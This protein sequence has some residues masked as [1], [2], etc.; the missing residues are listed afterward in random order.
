MNI[1]QLLEI[2]IE[3]RASDL[4]LLAGYPPMIRIHGE[5]VQVAGSTA[6]S[7]P[8]VTSL[9]FQLLT[10]TQ[11]Q[12][13]EKNFELDFGFSFE[14]KARFRANLYRQK[15]QMG[16]SLRMIPLAIPE[17]ETLGLPPAVNKLID[18]HQGFVLVTGPNGQGKSTTL[19]AVINKINSKRSAHIVTIED[20]IEYVYAKGKSIISQREMYLDTKS[21][22]SAL[23]AV[24]RE[25]IDVILIGEMRD[26]ETIA[27]AITI[28]ETGHLVLATL[29]TN[30]AAQSIDRMIDVFPQNQQ[31]QIRLQLAATLE[32]IV[33]QRLVPTIT[34]GRKLAVELLLRNSALPALIRESKTHLIDNLIQTSGEQGMI[35]LETSLANLVKEGEVDFNTALNYSF[36]PDLLAKLV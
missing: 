21:W 24:L 10:P 20:P 27:A 28:A 22:D 13:F 15:G 36:R 25:D 23:R 5:L 6:L 33:S 7:D 2:T 8:D 14:D 1:R 9:V 29:H 26:P 31:Q 35:S 17:L 4:H 32:A 16:A 3:R 34:P 12:L 11:K 18:L 19:A 30:S